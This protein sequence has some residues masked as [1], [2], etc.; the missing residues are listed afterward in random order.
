MEHAHKEERHE[1]RELGRVTRNWRARKGGLSE[2]ENIYNIRHLRF[3]EAFEL[4]NF[5]LFL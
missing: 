1:M 2:R 4:N 3:E 5:D